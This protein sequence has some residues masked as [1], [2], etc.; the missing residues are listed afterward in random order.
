MAKQGTAEELMKLASMIA[1]MS[2]AFAGM[3]AAGFFGEPWALVTT[4]L[5][6]CAGGIIAGAIEGRS[7]RERMF[8]AIPY[9]VGSVTAALAV[10]AY[11][12]GRSSIM[13]V[14]L[15]LP[16]A[17][18]LVPFALLRWFVARHVGPRPT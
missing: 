2:A 15:L 17:A 7:G 11:V 4:L 12:S 14:E 16:M 1:I 9:V 3:G 13:N 8:Y 10:S 18:G 6:P 5:V